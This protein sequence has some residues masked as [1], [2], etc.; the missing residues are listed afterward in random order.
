ML[1]LRWLA[2][3]ALVGFGSACGS[4]AEEEEQS[5]EEAGVEELGLGEVDDLKM[6]GG[7]G[8]ALT[9]K[10]IPA[11]PV[12]AQPKIVVSLDGLTLH[13]TDAASGFDKVFPIGPGKIEKGVSLTPLSLAKAGQVFYLRLDQAIG[14]EST[15]PSYAPFAMAYSCKIWWPD[16][17]TGKKVP[18]FAGLPFLRLEGA[19]SLGYAIHGPVDSYTIPSGG[20]LSRGFVSH[21]C[22]RMEAAD[23]SEVYARCLG[24]KVPVRLQKSVERRA[25]GNAVEVSS[26]WLLS[27]CEQN[28]DCNYSGGLCH[29]NPYGG[30][31]FCTSSC[32]KVCPDKF[33]YPVSF[34]V[35]DP[36]ND[37]EGICVLKGSGLNDTCRRYPGFELLPQEERFGQSSV[38]ADVCLPGSLGWVGSPCF[39]DPDCG[40]AGMDCNEADPAEGRPGFCT[41]GCT[42]YCPDSAGYPSTFCVKAES[43]GGECRPKCILPDDCLF[44]YECEANV[45]RYNQPSVKASVCL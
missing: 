34:C 45:P 13:L 1:K 30:R 23:V 26:R 39:T 3:L 24:R 19:P 16:P 40:F 14:K 33:G 6:D 28:K 17:T 41:Q 2:V 20:K 37:G 12:L 18:V 4:E 21:G 38:K 32:T 36:E 9:C 29:E 15:N 35:A 25:D 10:P 7:W 42:K 44:G 22:I 27:E 31:G 11:L 5:V 8:S 43:S